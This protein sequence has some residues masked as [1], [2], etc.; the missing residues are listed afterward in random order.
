VAFYGDGNYPVSSIGLG[1]GCI[2]DPLD[3]A[4]LEPDLYI[5][6]DDSIQTWTQTTYAEDS[7]KP[8]VVVNHGTSEEAGVRELN[9]HL[10]K[11]FEGYEII[12]FN[13]GCTYK[14]ITI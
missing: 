13:E 11:A 9:K 2:S 8:L 4:E 5:A 14:W 6:I 10:A 7:G 1:T 12:H 3:Y